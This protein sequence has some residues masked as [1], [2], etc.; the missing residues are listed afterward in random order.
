MLYTMR[1]ESIRDIG[2]TVCRTVRPMRTNERPTT[3]TLYL[4]ADYSYVTHVMFPR[5][6]H[7]PSTSTITD[8]QSRY[9]VQ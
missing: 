3:L 9:Q 5:T 6:R 7:R 2:T 8:R 4:A 1:L